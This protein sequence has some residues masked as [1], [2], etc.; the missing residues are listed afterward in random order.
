MARGGLQ[1]YGPSLHVFYSA[2]AFRL[3]FT[4]SRGTVPRTNAAGRLGCF[5]YLL[6]ALSTFDKVLM[7]SRIGDK[8][9][10]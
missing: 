2:N 9:L 1:S 7:E 4:H 6:L 10:T 5:A 3:F 8:Q